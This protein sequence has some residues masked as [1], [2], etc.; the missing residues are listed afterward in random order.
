MWRKILQLF[1][2]VIAVWLAVIIGL[3]VA[4]FTTGERDQAQPADV[5]IVLGSGLRRDGRPGDALYRRSLWAARLYQLDL[6]DAIICTGGIGQ[7]HVRSEAS[8]CAE[9]LRNEGVP[10]EAIVLEEQSRSTE[11]NALFASQIMQTHGWQTAN[12]VTDSFHMLRASWIFDIYG[13]QHFRSPVPRQWVRTHFFIRHF[14]R[15][16][17]ALHWQAFKEIFNLPHTYVGQL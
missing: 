8:A 2:I 12:L 13:I 16:I 17:L 15:E 4:I 10:T 14:S 5:I 1:L 7:G 9:V 11:E 3:M 6:A